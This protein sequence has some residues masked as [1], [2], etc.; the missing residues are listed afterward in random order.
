MVP[1]NLP[2]RSVLI[3]KVKIRIKIHFSHH[4]YSLGAFSVNKKAAPATLSK[5]QQMRTD[6]FGFGKAFTL[7]FSHKTGS[8]F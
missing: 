4:P 2:L 1:L 7:C 5:A 8:P 6:R 3:S